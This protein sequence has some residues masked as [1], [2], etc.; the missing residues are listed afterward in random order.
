MKSK[1]IFI[2]MLSMSFQYFSSQVGI[3]TTSPQSTLSVVN[4]NGGSSTDVLSVGNSNCGAPCLQVDNRSIVL[5]NRNGTNH[6]FGGIHFVPSG[7]STG[8]TGASI[9]GIDRDQTNGY[10]GLQFNTR[11]STDYG[12]RLTIKSS[13]DVG[14]GTA[15]PAAK[16]DI[17]GNIK[18]ADGTQGKDKVLT[19]DA[20][21]LAQWKNPMFAS[22]VDSF[23]T[24]YLYSGGGD[25]FFWAADAGWINNVQ[26]PLKLNELSD[27]NNVY[28]PATGIM[29]V[30]TEG[31]YYIK[32]LIRLVNQPGATPFNGSSGI[33]QGYIDLKPNG[34]SSFVTIAS[35]SKIVT[36]GIY[37]N[38]G[39]VS[40]DATPE[41]MVHLNVGDQI[42]LSFRT[43]GTWHINSDTINKIHITRKI[44]ELF[45]YKL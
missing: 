13:G 7:V 23:S 40:Y 27:P 41:T 37:I 5:Y 25:D 2:S 4:P 9:E 44:S 15:N 12:T 14:I 22:G 1:I 8:I 38:G 31:V 36:A 3:N 28:D 35:D 45:V 34:A 26:T 6:R 32:S 16:L 18:I 10:A 39:I 42:R 11:N 24:P 20:N 43:Y 17:A 33:F 30:L 29:T 21:G 19:S